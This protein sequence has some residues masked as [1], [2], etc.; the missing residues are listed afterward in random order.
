MAL[1]AGEGTNISNNPSL[2]NRAKRKGIS[3]KMILALIDVAKEKG[4]TER[5]KAYWRV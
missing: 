5:Q 2:V 4:E 3:R 1:V